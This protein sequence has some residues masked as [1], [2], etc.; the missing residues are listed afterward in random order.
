MGE[1]VQAVMVHLHSL[2]ELITPPAVL[3][4]AGEALSRCAEAGLKRWKLKFWEERAASAAA[5]KAVGQGMGWKQERGRAW[6]AWLLSAAPF[7]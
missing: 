7:P 3:E 4:T 1:T 6:K 2:A 5:G